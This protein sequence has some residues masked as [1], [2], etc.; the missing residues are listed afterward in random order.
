MVELTTTMDD[1]NKKKKKK[2]PQVELVI[3]EL[4]MGAWCRRREESVRVVPK[5][6]LM[7]GG[8]EGPWWVEFWREY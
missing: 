7:M 4:V 3:V 2:N 5:V 6:E 8:R 1:N